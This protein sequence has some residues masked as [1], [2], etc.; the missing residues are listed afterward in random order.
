MDPLECD[1]PEL[2]G[3]ISSRYTHSIISVSSRKRRLAY[4]FALVKA[5]KEQAILIGK[6]EHRLLVKSGVGLMNYMD[7]LPTSSL[8]LTHEL[9]WDHKTPEN[10]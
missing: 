7:A 3:D 8:Q 10:L 4:A 9:V 1:V 2:E 5:N 6:S